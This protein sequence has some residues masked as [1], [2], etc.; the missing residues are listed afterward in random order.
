MLYQS[1]LFVNSVIMYDLKFI[2][3]HMANNLKM[4]KMAS[5]IFG[6]MGGVF[7]SY[8]VILLIKYGYKL[9]QYLLR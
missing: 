6:F 8:L 4:N 7:L 2:I 3:V 9:F 5:Y 1:N